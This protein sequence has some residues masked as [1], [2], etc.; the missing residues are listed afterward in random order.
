MKKLLLFT[1][2]L[3]M[4]TGCSGEPRDIVDQLGQRYTEADLYTMSDNVMVFR[5]AKQVNDFVFEAAGLHEKTDHFIVVYTNGEQRFWIETV[6]MEALPAGVEWEQ[7]RLTGSGIDLYLFGCE[8][9]PCIGVFMQ[10]DSMT[11]QEIAANIDAIRYNAWTDTLN[12]IHPEG[13]DV[14]SGVRSD[15]DSAQIPYLDYFR[16]PRWIKAGGDTLIYH[17][18]T[19]SVN[20]FARWVSATDYE[21][22]AFL[23]RYENGQ[24]RDTGK[25][26][27]TEDHNGELWLDLDDGYYAL[28]FPIKGGYQAF[29]TFAVGEL[30]KLKPG[31]LPPGRRTSELE[32]VSISITV[33]EHNSE[34]TTLT[35]DTVYGDV[36]NCLPAAGGYGYFEFQISGNWYALPAKLQFDIPYDADFSTPSNTSRSTEYKLSHSPKAKHYYFF[37]LCPGTYRFA[38]DAHVSHYLL[39]MD[40]VAA[41]FKIS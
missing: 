11:P 4:L 9:W 7:P 24:W 3:L 21:N 20:G 22:R 33:N 35:L 28:V 30:S 40:F 29:Y 6:P 39:N 41:E 36:P 32:D 34:Q 16:K 12:F 17:F 26:Y 5:R 37:P 38:A 13:S 15:A 18:Q 23:R 8:Q 25:E 10:S 1:F 19:P 14:F 2:L 31:D 27:D